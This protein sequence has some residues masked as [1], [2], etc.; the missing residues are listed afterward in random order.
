MG[1]T[2]HVRPHLLEGFKHPAARQGI[3][4]LN[5]KNTASFYTDASK[6]ATGTGVAIYCSSRKRLSTAEAVNPKFIQNNTDAE[7]IALAI[8]VN[9]FDPGV[10]QTNIYS[11]STAAI[12]AITEPQ[13]QKKHVCLWRS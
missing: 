10:T 5:S 9:A 7:V 11:D 6:S 3:P 13:P 8:A 12:A 2:R 1:N 4:H